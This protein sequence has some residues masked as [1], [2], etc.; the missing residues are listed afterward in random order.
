MSLIHAAGLP[1]TE[2]PGI[3]A[4]DL[5][6]LITRWPGAFLPKEWHG[7][8]LLPKNWLRVSS[9]LKQDISACS[10][11]DKSKDSLSSI[12]AQ[13]EEKRRKMSRQEN[14]ISSH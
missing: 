3:W 11:L 9:L 4:G 13:K 7:S 6:G 1:R 10:S 8:A 2:E 12:T 5:G 14:P